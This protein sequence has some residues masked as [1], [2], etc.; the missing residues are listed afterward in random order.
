MIL[1]KN[2]KFTP[3]E[4]LTCENMDDVSSYIGEKIELFS[5]YGNYK[6]KQKK[7]ELLEEI[8]KMYNEDVLNPQ[9]DMSAMTNVVYSD[10]ADT[11]LMIQYLSLIHI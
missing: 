9:I 3:N 6:S 8:L 10:K 7:V 11:R 1:Q 2:F 4:G 5:N